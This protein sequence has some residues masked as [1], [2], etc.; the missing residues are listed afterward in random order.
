MKPAP[1]AYH[2][3][4]SLA[5]AVTLLATLD[6]PRLLAG[7]QSLMP[8][9]NYRL[10]TPDHLIDLRRIEALRGIRMSDAGLEIGAM[11]TQRMIQNSVLVAERCPLLIQALTHVGHQ[12]TRN[13][14]TLG[15]SLCHLDPAAEL[16]LAAQVLQPTLEIASNRGVRT[17][18]FAEFPL[19]Q[20]SNRL[21]VDEILTRVVFPRQKP[22]TRTAF[23]EF[24]RR[25][26]DFAIVAIAAQVTT[27]DA[28]V[29]TDARIAVAGTAPVAV[30]L[31]EAEQRLIGGRLTDAA[32]GHVAVIAGRHPADGDSNNPA[33]YRR[34]LVSV[35][36]QRALGRLI[37]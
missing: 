12:T 3:P 28:G 31:Q 19:G 8:M 33:E 24:A 4:D 35:L 37:S 32:T 36:T 20:L 18:P 34:H 15:G 16:P 1:F 11:T 17:L 2:A 21:D 22:H 5:E 27:D 14:G 10:A 7:G 9:L 6:N 26:G 23:E 25:P 30:R 13:C 29:I